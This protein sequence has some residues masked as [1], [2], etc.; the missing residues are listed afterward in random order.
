MKTNAARILDSLGIPYEL[1]E[2]DVDPE[3][4]DAAAVAA[5][6]GMPA[7]Q[8]F[9]TLLVEGDRNGYAFAVIPGS[10]EL[11]FKVLAKL[12]GDRAVTMAPLKQV[13]PLTGYVRGGV[14]VFG[15]RKAFPV[16]VDETIE[17]WDEVSVS[18]GI[19]GTQVILSPA[20]YLRATEAVVGPIARM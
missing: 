7:E 11:D 16:Y 10:A 4:L 13:Q 8:V 9:K 1:R 20:G 18:A 3:H 17:L 12:S 2:Y 6:V 15:A 14:T 5:K 19:R